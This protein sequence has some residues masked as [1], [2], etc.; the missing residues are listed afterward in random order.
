MTRAI[1]HN[2]RFKLGELV[3]NLAFPGMSN[4]TATRRSIL[5]A[6]AAGAGCLAGASSTPSQADDSDFAGAAAFVRSAGNEL[7]RLAPLAK[8]AAPDRKR[9][10]DFIDTVVDVDAV[11]KFSIGRFWRTATAEQQKRYLSLFHDILFLNITSRLGD[12]AQG[13]ASVTIGRP[14]VT[15]NGISVPTLVHRDG[16]PANTVTWIL[17]GDAARLRIIDVVVEGMS[18]RLTLRND[19]TAFIS[20]NGNDIAVLLTAMAKQIADRPG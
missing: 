4:R 1:A 14:Q 6:L 5:L 12:Y 8:A 19:Y 11:A 18:M 17:E 20:R 15:E 7:A 10:Q 16:N 9:L 2:P 3:A 13:T